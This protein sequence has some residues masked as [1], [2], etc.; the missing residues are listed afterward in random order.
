MKKIYIG[1]C[2]HLLI[3]ANCAKKKT[4]ISEIDI[5]RLLQRISVNRITE[6]L[7]S[8]EATLI[9]DDANLFLESCDVLR[10]EPRETLLK[11]KNINPK[12]YAHLAGNNEN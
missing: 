6:H 7:D 3:F 11:I 10:L 9:K 4:E 8:K 1:L 5:N 2:L 12:L